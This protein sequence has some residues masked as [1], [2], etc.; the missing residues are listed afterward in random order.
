MPKNKQ[1]S[2]YYHRTPINKYYIGISHNPIKR[3]GNQGYGYHTQQKFY[4]AIL[5]Y[6]WDN[7]EHVIVASDLTLNEA[8]K[9]EKEL[10]KKYNAFNHGYN[11]DLGGKGAEGHFVSKQAKQRMR[12]AKLGKKLTIQHKQQLKNAHIYPI[13]VYSITGKFLNSYKN[14][15]EASKNLNIPR[16]SI[17]NACNYLS[18][19]N[20]KYI[21]LN[22]KN[23]NLLE[24]KLQLYKEKI[25]TRELDTIFQYDL[26]GNFINS[27]KT[28]IEASNQTK[29]SIGA[30]GQSCSGFLLYSKNYFFLHSLDEIEIKE[31]VENIKKTKSIKKLNT[32][33]YYNVGQY[34]LDGTLIA[35]YKT[36]KEASLATGYSKKTINQNCLNKCKTVG[37]KF[38][39]KKILL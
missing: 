31:R 4:R 24:Q 8:Y 22:D 10:I 29:I 33:K 11:A 32:N 21:F 35:I 19:Y 18:D 6:G 1:Y 16:S 5:K 34:T 39:F 15:E 23:Y 26:E 38:I 28:M 9:L 30:I 13:Y 36:Y 14:A 27:Y 25:K 2:V 17:I 20:D 7:I 12:K 3:W 37:R